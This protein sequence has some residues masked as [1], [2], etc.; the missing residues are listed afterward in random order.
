VTDWAT[1]AEV[2]T[3]G[4]TLVLAVATFASVRSAN[5][6]AR[7]ADRAARIAEE[8]LLAGLRP[9]I[10]NSRLQDPQQKVT[11]VEGKLLALPGGRAAFEL[12][13]DV[14]YMS[15]S[16]RN[17]GSGL[18]VLHGWYVCPAVQRDR[19][20]PPLEDFTSQTRDIFVAPGDIGFWQAAF[21]DPA[22]ESFRLATAAIGAGN[23]VTVFL[24][25]GDFEGGQRVISQFN[26]RQ[27]G[28]SWMV[29]AVRHFNVDRP[30]PR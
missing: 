8:T 21:R 26:A 22:A 29:E 5:R 18:G 30:E 15:L 11:F 27:A 9:L 10:V 25:Y 13:D 4:G 17:V 12:T 28:D 24:L 1:L 6:S 3:A 7:T 20:H 16:I 2:A 19:A 23:P 14:V